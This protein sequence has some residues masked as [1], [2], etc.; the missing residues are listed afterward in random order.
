[1]AQNVR[2]IPRLLLFCERM[3]KK[4]QS[5]IYAFFIFERCERTRYWSR[6]F[7]LSISAL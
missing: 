7:V 2:I 3:Q 5:G 4:H 6:A 1:V